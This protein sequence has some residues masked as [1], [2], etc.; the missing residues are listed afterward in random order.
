MDRWYSYMF[1]HKK[2]IEKMI[3]YG[4]IV[5]LIARLL[6]IFLLGGTPDYFF[7]G[8]SAVL[9]AFYGLLIP[10][11]FAILFGGITTIFSNKKAPLVFIWSYKILYWILI[12]S[13]LINTVITISKFS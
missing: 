5:I 8:F 3:K 13:V 4:F 6:P 11:F 7:L 1:G 9:T 2:S 12:T 10:L